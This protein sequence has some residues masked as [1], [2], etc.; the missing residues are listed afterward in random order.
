[1]VNRRFAPTL[2]GLVACLLVVGCGG[3]DETTS[4]YPPGVSQP[5]AK[6]EFL[7]QADAICESTNARV[8]A[9]ADDLVGGA[10]DPPP[11]QVERIVRGIVVPALQAEVDAIGARRARHRAHPR[12]DP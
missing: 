4:T 11:A 5:I 2:G 10:H 12:R 9:A 3:G 8:E 7:R 6:V 1:V